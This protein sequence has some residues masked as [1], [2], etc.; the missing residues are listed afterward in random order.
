MLEHSRIKEDA[1]K[2][3]RLVAWLLMSS[4]VILSVV[5]PGLRP[6]TALP[7]SAEHF[8]IFFATG[9]AFM[10]GYNRYKFQLVIGLIGFAGLVEIVQI[11]IPGRHARLSDF[12]VDAAALPL[13]MAIA[14]LVRGIKVTSG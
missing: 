5:P 6:E 4:I 10:F 13:G 2:A 9:A 7:H 8:G 3:A 12:I 14:S 1:V 11:F